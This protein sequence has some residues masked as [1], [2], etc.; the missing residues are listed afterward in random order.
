VDFNDADVQDEY[1]GLCHSRAT[2]FQVSAGPQYFQLDRKPSHPAAFITDLTGD[3]SPTVAI[4]NSSFD[5]FGVNNFA[6]VSQ[7]ADR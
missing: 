4:A 6:T 3:F 7:N 5:I 2:Y 1:S